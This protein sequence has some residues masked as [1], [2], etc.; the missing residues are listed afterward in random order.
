LS[1]TQPTQITKSTTTTSIKSTR[2]SRKKI[3]PKQATEAH[4]SSSNDNDADD[5]DDNILDG[6]V[7]FIAGRTTDVWSNHIVG[8]VSMLLKKEQNE[9]QS[10]CYT[11]KLILTIFD[12]FVII[13]PQ[14]SRLQQ[15]VFSQ[16]G[17]SNDRNGT[18]Q[19]K[20]TSQKLRL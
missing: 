5:H 12:F 17:Q 9:T 16:N 1:F 8:A 13:Y 14:N 4:H 3:K 10:S 7:F 18:V 11:G 19:L 2:R 6:T 15:N 20:R